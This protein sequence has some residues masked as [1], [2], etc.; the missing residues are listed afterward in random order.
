MRAGQHT[1]LIVLD[2]VLQTDH[3]GVIFVVRIVL[4]VSEHRQ[5]LQHALWQSMAT[6]AALLAYALVDHID[7]LSDKQRNPVRAKTSH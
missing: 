7:N 3:A 6:Q 1:Q 2:E 5:L 4:G